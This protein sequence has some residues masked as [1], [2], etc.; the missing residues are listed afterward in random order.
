MWHWKG[1]KTLHINILRYLTSSN[2]K[3]ENLPKLEISE[4]SVH[5]IRILFYFLLTIATITIKITLQKTQSTKYVS[6]H[7][8][9]HYLQQNLQ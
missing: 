9:P 4:R 1:L 3:L 5:G 6:T 7:Y 8:N 2:K